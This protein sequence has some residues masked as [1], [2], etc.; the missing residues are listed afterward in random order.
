[1]S[2]LEGSAGRL[3]QRYRCPKEFIIRFVCME[4]LICTL[5]ALS[6]IPYL[7]DTPI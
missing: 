1:M 2:R 7:R 3:Q 5:R 4:Y 6:V